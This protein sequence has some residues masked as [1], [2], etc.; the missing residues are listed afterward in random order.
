LIGSQ[1]RLERVVR[2]T[3]IREMY[4]LGLRAAMTSAAEHHF[5]GV[6]AAD[7]VRQAHAQAPHVTKYL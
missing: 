5:A 1:L 6:V 4:G 2:E 3:E 7:A